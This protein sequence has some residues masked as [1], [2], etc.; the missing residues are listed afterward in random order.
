MPSEPAH[1]LGLARLYRLL[2][3]HHVPR[4]RV[5]AQRTP[6]AVQQKVVEDYAA[7]R[8]VYDIA[9]RHGVSTSTVSTIAWRHY[10]LR[11]PH[12]DRDR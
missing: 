10:R 5:H 11:H 1:Q 12:P 4:R 3:E 2:D 8:S 9:K 6:E 7:G